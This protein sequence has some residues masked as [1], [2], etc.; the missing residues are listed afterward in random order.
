MRG[1]ALSEEDDALPLVRRAFLRL[2]SS[3]CEEGM[4]SGEALPSSSDSTSSR[5]RLRGVIAVGMLV[6]RTC[7]TVDLSATKKDV[8]AKFGRRA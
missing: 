1:V 7:R 5:D 3:G 4:R 2:G 6:D 8:F